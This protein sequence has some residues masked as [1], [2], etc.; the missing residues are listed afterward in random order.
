MEDK[1]LVVHADF[2]NGEYRIVELDSEKEVIKEMVFPIIEEIIEP[3]KR[4]DY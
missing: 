2:E 1:V 3:G 4:T